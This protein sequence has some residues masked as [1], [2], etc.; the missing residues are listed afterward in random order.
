ME[1]L[2]VWKLTPWLQLDVVLRLVMAAIVGGIIGLDRERAHKPAGIRTLMLVSVGSAL[3]TILSIYGFGESAD[4][5][6]IAAGIVV[7][8]GF[9]G[10]GV[11][12][13]S[14]KGVMGLTTAAAVWAVAATGVAFGCG[15][16]VIAVA[17]TVLI[18][19]ALRLKTKHHLDHE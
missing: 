13:H 7:G 11:I 5:S 8:I 17:T 4:P 1:A 12:L 10:A 18:L 2:H 14:E 3:F 15:L 16:Y 19:V 9:L 6:R